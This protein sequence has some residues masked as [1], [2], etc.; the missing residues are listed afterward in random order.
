MNTVGAPKGP[1]GDD[2]ASRGGGATDS[3]MPNGRSSGSG[4]V[5]EP[6]PWPEDELPPSPKP[7]N[8]WGNV[9]GAA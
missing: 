7:L 3:A 4:E 6:G 8:S 2:E 9:S 1:A 5:I